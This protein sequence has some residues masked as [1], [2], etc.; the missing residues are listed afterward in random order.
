VERIFV[1]S[2][3]GFTQSR[4]SVLCDTEAPSRRVNG[5]GMAVK[6]DA[7]TGRPVL[8]VA[9]GQGSSNAVIFDLTPVRFEFLSRVAEGALPGSFSNECLE[10]MMA[11]K[12]KLLRK[13][14]IIRGGIYQDEDDEVGE[15]SGSLTL[16]F[17]D[18]EQGGHGF[19]R[20]ITVRVSE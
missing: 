2:S 19:S 3:G 10:D 7:R 17:I 9:L 8:D 1:A 18:I 13:A 20:P 12:A 14:E 15:D 11:F 16:N 4:V 6:L 5:I